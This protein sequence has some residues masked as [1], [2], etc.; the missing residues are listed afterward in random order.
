MD[1]TEKKALSAEQLHA[2]AG[3][4][5]AL[6]DPLRL[7]ILQCLCDQPRCVS[8]IVAAVGTTQANVSKHLRKLVNHGVLHP[9]NAGR[10][11]FYT[12]S[13]GLPLRLCEVVHAQ[14]D[15]LPG[16]LPKPPLGKN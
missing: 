4:F 1:S 12:L 14:I 10:N 9:N 11:V 16:R 3:L 7:A 15:R 13:D 2:V 5:R 6:C 8:E